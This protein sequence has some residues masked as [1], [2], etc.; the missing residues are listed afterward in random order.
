MVPLYYAP[1][2]SVPVPGLG[3]GRPLLFQCYQRL[4]TKLLS[5]SPFIMA[6]QGQSVENPVTG[7]SLYFLST[8]RQTNGRE[9]VLESSYHGPGPEPRP[10]YHPQQEELFEVLQGALQVRLNG[11][12]RTLHRGEKLRIAPGQVHS[13]WNEQPG[14]TIVRWTTRP[15]LRTEELLETTFT[16][17]Q[18]GLVTAEGAPGLLQSALLLGEFDQE[19]RLARPPR[20]V[21]RLVFGLLRPVARFI[22]LRASYGAQSE[23]QPTHARRLAPDQ[24]TAHGAGPRVLR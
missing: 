8:A 18:A 10:H 19:F 5:A 21:Q 4:S 20:L 1:C 2:S 13:M 22:G 15:A 3:P 24:R 12:L 23:P 9:L 17:A 14:R 16:L 11:Q 6:Y 7:Q